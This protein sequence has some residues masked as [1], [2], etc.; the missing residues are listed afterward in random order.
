MG[1]SYKYLTTFST[2]IYN[3][4]KDFSADIESSAIAVRTPLHLSFF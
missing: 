4:I 1:R 3:M 2:K